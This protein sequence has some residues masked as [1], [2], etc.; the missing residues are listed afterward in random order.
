VL[1]IFN[2]ERYRDKN[3]AAVARQ[4]KQFLAFLETQIENP[5]NLE[6]FHDAL[7]DHMLMIERSRRRQHVS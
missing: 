3:L 6:T 4:H 5:G 7:E 2:F 1:I